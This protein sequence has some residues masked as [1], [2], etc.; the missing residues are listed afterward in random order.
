MPSVLKSYSLCLF[1]RHLC[2]KYLIPLYD[3]LHQSSSTTPFAFSRCSSLA[4]DCHLRQLFAD[5]TW[6]LYQV[7]T[8]LESIP[9]VTAG[10][11]GQTW[12]TSWWFNSARPCGSSSQ[13]SGVFILCSFFSAPCLATADNK[14]GPCR[15]SRRIRLVNSYS[16]ASFRSVCPFLFWCSQTD[17]TNLLR[18]A[19]CVCNLR[20]SGGGGI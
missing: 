11:P 10:W 6:W 2:A 8:L 3:F 14:N 18:L 1:H 13:G 7:G 5:H 4:E 19:G 12:V 16:A 17:H 15:A 9:V 20:S